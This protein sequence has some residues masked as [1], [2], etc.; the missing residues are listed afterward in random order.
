[1]NHLVCFIASCSWL[2]K[3]KCGACRGN[4]NPKTSRPGRMEALA[5]LFARCFALWLWVR[6]YVPRGGME[7]SYA[8]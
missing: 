3:L 8:A 7:P 4:L 5:E 2:S 1:M 6:N